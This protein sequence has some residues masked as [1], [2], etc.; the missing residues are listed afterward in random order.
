MRAAALPVGLNLIEGQA[1]I[2]RTRAQHAPHVR[3]IAAAQL[4]KYR[5]AEQHVVGV[6]GGHC[7]SIKLLKGLVEVSDQ[8]LMV[9]A[10]GRIRSGQESQHDNLQ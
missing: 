4:A 7:L 1:E 3:H 10:H 5:V 6:T 9:L 8:R 2:L